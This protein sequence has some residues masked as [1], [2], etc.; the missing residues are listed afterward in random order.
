MS[1]KKNKS[2]VLTKNGRTKL[3]GIARV[4]LEEMMTNAKPKLKDKIVNRLK[5]IK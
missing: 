4:K 3:K 1:V 2:S 5:L